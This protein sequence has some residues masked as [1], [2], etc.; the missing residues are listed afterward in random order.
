M[1]RGVVPGP[2]GS[3]WHAGCLI[4]GGLEAK[5]KRKQAGKAGCGKKLDS[6]AKVDAEGGVW[7]RE[8][9]V[10]YLSLPLAYEPLVNHDIS[11]CCLNIYAKRLP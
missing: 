6:G 7:C 5:G 9:L 10:S 2:Q 8:C 1:E 4:C 3:K 11:F